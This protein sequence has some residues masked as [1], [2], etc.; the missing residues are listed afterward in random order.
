M[1][2]GPACLRLRALLNDE[3][4]ASVHSSFILDNEKIDQ[5][6]DWVRAH[7]RDRLL[8]E[9]LADPQLLSEVQTAMDQLT[10]ILGMGAFYEFQQ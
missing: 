8:P 9:D 7:Y 3:E 6:A 10:M 5:L 1:A 4:A 2:A